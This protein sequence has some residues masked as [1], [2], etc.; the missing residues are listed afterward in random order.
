MID[1]RR[2]LVV[3][4]AR[5]IDAARASYPNVLTAPSK[6][7]KSISGS[8]WESL[9]EVELEEILAPIVPKEAVAREPSQVARL[10]D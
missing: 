9:D 3:A 2:N 5:P 6:G 1:L 8:V 7:G 10:V 4:A